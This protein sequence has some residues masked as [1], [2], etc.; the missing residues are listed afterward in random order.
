MRVGERAVKGSVLRV[1][2]GSTPLGSYLGPNRSAVA[3]AEKETTS[4]KRSLPLGDR[5]RRFLV[6]AVPIPRARLAV[7][8]LTPPSRPPPTA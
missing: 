2:T 3:D 1:V 7:T 6:Q 4:D 5:E 8:P